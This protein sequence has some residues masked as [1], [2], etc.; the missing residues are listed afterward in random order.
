MPNLILTRKAGQS[1][2]LLVEGEALYLDVLNVTGG[3]CLMRVVSTQ[4]PIH[5]EKIRFKGTMQIAEGVSVLVVDLARGHAKLNFTAPKEV[6]I[7]RTE[8]VKEME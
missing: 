4:H 1:V 5:C 8:L 6:Q 3:N 7:L 2:R